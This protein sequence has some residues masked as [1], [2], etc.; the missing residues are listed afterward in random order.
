MFESKSPREFDLHLANY[1]QL[2]QHAVRSQT[3]TARGEV[4]P[5]IRGILRQQGAPRHSRKEGRETIGLL[6]LAAGCRRIAKIHNDL[7]QY[8]LEAV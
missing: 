3:A 1:A 5:K 4:G 7:R 6:D 8:Q 2:D